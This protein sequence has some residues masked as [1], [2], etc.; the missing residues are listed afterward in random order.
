MQFRTGGR[1]VARTDRTATGARCASVMEPG[2][3]IFPQGD[4]TRIDDDARFDP[5]HSSI[6]PNEM[7]LLACAGCGAPMR[8]NLDD[9]ILVQNDDSSLHSYH[10]SHVP[11][12]RRRSA[13]SARDFISAVAPS[14]AIRPSRTPSYGDEREASAP[15]RPH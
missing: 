11:I 2:T 8:T 7:I 15:L 12:D 4:I 1:N 14:A 9:F 13:F 10:R 6:V 3:G 5:G